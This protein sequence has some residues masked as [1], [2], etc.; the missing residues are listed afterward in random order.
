MNPNSK[1]K[2]LAGLRNVIAHVYRDVD[3]SQLYDFLGD[4]E[5]VQDFRGMILKLLE[6]R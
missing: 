6:N 5:C 1:L 3:Y 2:E 4:L